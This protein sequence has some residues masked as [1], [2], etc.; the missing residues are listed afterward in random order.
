ML[1]FDNSPPFNLIMN[2]LVVVQTLPFLFLNE[3]RVSCIFWFMSTT[4]LSRNQEVK[5]I[6]SYRSS[7]ASTYYQ[8]A[9]KDLGILNYF[10]SLKALYSDGL[11]LKQ[12]K[13][14]KDILERSNMLDAKP[15]FT[16]LLFNVSLTIT[17]NHAVNQVSQFLNSPTI[18]HFQHVKRIF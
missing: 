1:G 17:F 13:Y 5:N 14:A 3:T 12:T 8:F 6:I 10:L 9:I 15:V 7:L 18:T 2:S 4:I 11:C 16:P